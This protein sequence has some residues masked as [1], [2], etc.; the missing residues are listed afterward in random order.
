MASIV[1]VD[2]NPVTV[3]FATDI[4][5]GQPPIRFF[6]DEAAV[7]SLQYADN[8][9]NENENTEGHAGGGTQSPEITAVTPAPLGSNQFLVTYDRQVS[10]EDI[11]QARRCTTTRATATTPRGSR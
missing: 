8:A 1:N 10:V 9:D 7:R 6:V 11:S 5:A 4:N 2:E 3:Q